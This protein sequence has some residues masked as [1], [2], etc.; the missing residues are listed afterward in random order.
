MFNFL[1]VED[2]QIIRAQGTAF[3]NHDEILEKAYKE[4]E[5]AASHLSK[6]L[7]QQI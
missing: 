4:A 7:A 3:L 1:G 5:A 6:V 2:Y